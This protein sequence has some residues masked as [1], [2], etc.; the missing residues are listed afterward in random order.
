[1]LCAMKRVS[2]VFILIFAFCGLADSIYLAQNEIG[3]TPLICTVDNL[4]DCNIVAAS[5]YSRLFGIPLA[6]FG[7]AF[8]SIV[9][10]LAALELVLFNKLLRRLLQG[11]SLIGIIASLYFTFVEIF[12]IHALCIYCLVS[13]FITFLI[14]L[15]ASF[16]EPVRKNV[17]RKPPMS[18][19]IPPP[20]HFSMPPV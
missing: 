19:T 6:E 10:I 4:S 11:V 3:N 17:R 18:P 1:M 20:P 13:A 2:V 9:F 8:F 5:Q 7:I 16:I 12:V 15:F 14:F